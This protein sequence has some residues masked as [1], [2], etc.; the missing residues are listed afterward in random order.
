MACVFWHPDRQLICSVHGDD[1][2][3]G[4]PKE[5]L[6][7]FKGMVEAKYEL[8]ES[9]RLGSASTDDKEGR[10]LNRIIKWE[11]DGLTYEAD[12]RQYEKL[13]QELGLSGCET[14]ATPVVKVTK[15]DLDKDQSHTEP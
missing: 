5:A 13:T 11:E 9:V 3:T 15:E 4:G 8:K 12:P 6:D 1:F 10:I 14:V 2:T 7:W